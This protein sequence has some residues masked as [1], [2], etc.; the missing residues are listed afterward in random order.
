MDDIIILML[1]DLN[2]LFVL[3]QE[4]KTVAILFQL[5]V[6]IPVR[7]GKKCLKIWIFV[8]ELKMLTTL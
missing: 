1:A 2:I 8:E 5:K 6:D 3:V 7:A 4:L